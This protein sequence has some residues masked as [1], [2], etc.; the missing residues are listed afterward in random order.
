MSYSFCTVLSNFFLNF[1]FKKTYSWIVIPYGRVNKKHQPVCLCQFF[2]ITSTASS[3]LSFCKRRNNTITAS[4]EFL[5]RVSHDYIISN[6]Y[7][8]VSVASCKYLFSFS[9][10]VIRYRLGHYKGF[11]ADS[12]KIFK[13]YHLNI[14]IIPFNESNTY[15][16]SWH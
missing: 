10:T 13:R 7:L 3:V 11:S 12:W 16:N 8:V 15:I 14:H 2:R 5:K 4:M 1:Q 9:L 6:Q